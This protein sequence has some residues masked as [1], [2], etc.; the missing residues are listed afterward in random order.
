MTDQDLLDQAIARLKA[1]DVIEYTGEFGAEITT[2]IPFVFWLKAQGLLKGRRVVT[3]RGMRP[4]YYVLADDEYQE[5]VDLRQWLPVEERAWPT[6]STY[7]ATKQTWHIMPDYRE[8][9]RNGGRLFQRPVMFIQNKFAVEWHEG[10]VNYLPLNA[11]EHLLNSAADRFDIVY[12]RPREFTRDLGFTK[13]DGF[14]CEYPDLPLVK[15][16][17]NVLVLEEFCD[18]TGVPYNL[19]KLEILAKAHFFVAVQ[20]GGSH[21][22][23]CFG[24]SLM[25]LL[26]NRG[27]EYPHAYAAGPYKYLSTPPPTLMLVQAFDQLVWGIDLLCSVQLQNG[28]G[29]LSETFSSTLDLLRI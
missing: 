12:S 24:N 22:L 17:S 23:A 9:Y 14:Y 13:D 4:F 18:Q 2:F 5:K 19:T 27:D 8:R 29:T 26:H 15:R 11:L 3:Y 21:L 16:Y 1:T 10:P 28:V 25:L 20:G 6:N 7:T